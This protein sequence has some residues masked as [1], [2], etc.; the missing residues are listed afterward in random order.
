M[1]P[2]LSTASI[3]RLLSPGLVVINV[4]C[5]VNVKLQQKRVQRKGQK[6]VK[7]VIEGYRGGDTLLRLVLRDLLYG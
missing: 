7:A 1:T 3:S 6:Y 2:L 4:V 5:I